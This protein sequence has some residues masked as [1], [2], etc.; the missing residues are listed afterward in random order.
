MGFLCKQ[1]GL[2]NTINSLFLSLFLSPYNSIYKGFQNYPKQYWP[3]NK[4]IY[5]VAYQMQLLK[6]F[7]CKNTRN[8][9][10]KQ[11][12]DQNVIE[13][14]LYKCLIHINLTFFKTFS[15]GK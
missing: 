2:P 5:F 15:F 3:P 9:W 10:S 12:K 1:L 11:L 8:F 6:Q 7:T 4:L 13:T 14:I